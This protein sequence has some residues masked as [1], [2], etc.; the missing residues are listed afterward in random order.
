MA[1][2]ASDQAG[3]AFDDRPGDRRKL[4]QSAA[5][6]LAAAAALAGGTL[7]AFADT[8]I[9]SPPAV[10]SGTIKLAVGLASGAATRATNIVAGDT[11]AR[12]VDLGSTGATRAARE[13]TLKFSAT[14]TSLLDSDPVNGL[15]LS[16]RACSQAWKRA[17]GAHPPAS[18]YTCTPGAI[19]V[20][21]NGATKASVRS[22]EVTA[23]ALTPLSSLAPGGSDFL[24]FEL[25][26]PAGAPGDLSRVAACSGKFAGTAATEDLQGCSSTL[27][28]TFQST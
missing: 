9:I 28:Y 6:V 26:L 15:Q 21:I 11:I 7:A 17:V 14:P 22:L 18:E 24:L 4:I 5:L 3:D 27:I 12:E 23:A 2:H 16:I 8:A 10:A 25:T 1:S 20:E 13:I 19:P